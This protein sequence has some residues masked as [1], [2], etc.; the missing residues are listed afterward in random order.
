VLFQPLELVMIGGAAVGAFFVGNNNKSIKAT[1]KALPT[2]FK[3]SRTPRK[4]TWS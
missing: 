1:M 2:V 4:C 3:G